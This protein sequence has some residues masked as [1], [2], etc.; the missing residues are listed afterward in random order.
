MRNMEIIYTT[1]I[2]IQKPSDLY[3][4]LLYKMTVSLPDSTLYN[5]QVDLNSAAM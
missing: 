2:Q 5:H 1:A 4:E 3:T